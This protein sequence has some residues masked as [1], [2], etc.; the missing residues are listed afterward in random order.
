M[1]RFPAQIGKY[2]IIDQIAKGGM[3]AVFKAEHPTLEREIIIKKLTLRGHQSITERFRREARIMMGFRHE[4]I[5][6][7]YDHFKEKSSYYIVEEYV[8]GVSLDK[9]VRRERY[10]P[11]DIALLIF[12][13]ACR[14]LKYAHDKDVVHRDIKPENILISNDGYVKLCDFG[15]ASSKEDSDVGLTREGMTLGTPSYM[16]PEQIQDTRAVDKRGDIYSM[17]VMLYEM[18][19]GKKPFPGSFTPD[20]VM[21]IQKGNFRP[22]GK[23][24]PKV[25]GLIRKIIRRSI[26]PKVKKR[27]QDLQQVINLIERHFR[28]HDVSA[29]KDLIRDFVAGQDVS[30]LRRR[31]GG[32]VR[33]AVIGTAAGVLLLAG[34]GYYVYA[35]GYYHEF[36][37]G[38]EFG[39]MVISA[40]V[41]KGTKPPDQLYVD[42][43]LYREDGNELIRLEE[44]S[45][46]FRVVPEEETDDY[47]VVRSRKLYLQT[48]AYRA[49][50]SLEGKL[51]WESFFLEP[52]VLQRRTV[53]TAEARTV[54]VVVGQGPSVPLDVQFTASDQNTGIDLTDSANLSVQV[55]GR[56]VA[57]DRLSPPGLT[58]GNVY[59]FLVDQAGYFPR[60]FHLIIAPFQTVLNLDV[61]M[62]P[63]PGTLRVSSPRA[64][65]D[66]KLN[67]SDY[68]V[69]GGRTPELKEVDV[70]GE[71][72]SEFLLPPG[73]YLV[74]AAMS[75][76]AADT[77]RVL[78]ES[79]RTTV[80]R[81]DLNETTR[82]L[83][84][85][86]GD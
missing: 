51:I 17:G 19:T 12:L 35:S 26:Q 55:D 46:S 73:E 41:R 38:D 1:A 14:A 74:N 53:S 75:R 68:Y 82:E 42:A 62:V 3:G 43:V 72:P 57:V 6:D 28:R 36:F 63:E 86:V 64:G 10:L 50:V 37:R 47:Y 29:G 32:S 58:T 5:V 31:K 69:S 78:I 33:Q 65:I 22:V 81:I 18:V 76:R 24:N 25:N 4:H 70:T 16:S 30:R 34:A 61:T 84:L 66:L 79:N 8:D 54:N 44:P 45:V 2:K 56:W 60:V 20:T 15:I 39:A 77:K 52:R 59:K 71:D 11:N 49:K 13:D 83:T 21:M 67:D 48:A 23:V 40:K 7:V 85:H 9:L 80:V 27:F